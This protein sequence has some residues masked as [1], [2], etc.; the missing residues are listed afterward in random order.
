MTS[1]IDSLVSLVDNFKEKI[2]DNEYM[3][4]MNTIGLARQSQL[5]LKKKLRRL[6]RKCYK[7]HYQLQAVTEYAVSQEFDSESE[8]DLLFL[9]SF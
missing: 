6:R 4:I 8:A 1:K 7:I 5:D 9:E 2:T 3:V